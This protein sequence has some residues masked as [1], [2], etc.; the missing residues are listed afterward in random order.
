MRTKACRSN[1]NGAGLGWGEAGLGWQFIPMT[2]SGGF[3]PNRVSVCPSVSTGRRT[4]YW[5]VIIGTGRERV[6]GAW[7]RK[8]VEEG[9]HDRETTPKTSH[10]GSDARSSH[11][12]FHE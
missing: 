11:D 12:M 7:I 6:T 4:H 5:W 3:P 2:E 8:V 9:M 1:L 10:L